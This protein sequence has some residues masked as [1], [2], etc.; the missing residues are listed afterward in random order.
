MW[1]R[2]LRIGRFWRP[3]HVPTGHRGRCGPQ[4]EPAPSAFRHVG[5]T[6]NDAS[7]EGVASNRF[8]S[9]ATDS[10]DDQIAERSCSDIYS[11]PTHTRRRLCYAQQ[12]P[13]TQIDSACQTRGAAGTCCLTC[14]TSCP[15][16]CAGAK[17][18]IRRQQ[19]S[20]FNVLMW[21]AAAGDQECAVLQW[22]MNVGQ[23]VESMS[24]AGTTK[25]DHIVSHASLG[26][27]HRQGFQGQDLTMAA[28]VD[29]H[30]SALEVVCVQVALLACRQVPLPVEP[31]LHEAVWGTWTNDPRFLKVS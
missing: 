18:G 10:D 3:R 29:V 13:V 5:V 16:S 22:L 31:I 11:V 14:E 25:S 24:V 9:F 4:Q 17:F 12:V 1:T 6:G 28:T 2:S 30:V 15:Q 23:H 20:V 21:A 27:I 26:R 19:W 8:F 7:V